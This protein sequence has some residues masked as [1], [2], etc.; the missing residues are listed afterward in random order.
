M[1]ESAMY[2]A[3]QECLLTDEE[4]AMGAKAWQ[5]FPDPFPAWNISVDEALAAQARTTFTARKRFR[6]ISGS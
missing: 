5:Q 3:L 1:D 6:R 2:D 4:F